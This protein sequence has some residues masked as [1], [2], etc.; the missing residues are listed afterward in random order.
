MVKAEKFPN[1]YKEVYEILKNVPKKD[2]NKIP[3]N[4]IE[5]IQKN[6]NN[7]YEFI[8]D[9]NQNFENMELMLETKTV[10]A[11]I[12][13]NYWGTEE[14]TKTVKLRL[15]QDLKEAEETKRQLYDVDI[16]QNKKQ[17]VKEQVEMI[18]YKKENFF[19][20]LFNKLKSFFFK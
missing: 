20:K 4:F 6:M 5:M 14:Q 2:F 16:F 1:A 11:Y 17:D 7:E 19:V 15:K 10:L 13:L 12:F 18:V 8:V 3:Q 9:K